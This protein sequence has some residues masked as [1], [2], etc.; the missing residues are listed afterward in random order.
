MNTF[1]KKKNEILLFEYIHQ[2]YQMQNLLKPLP[3]Y[4]VKYT[5]NCNPPCIKNDNKQTI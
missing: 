5:E 3:S 2:I 4:P 1:Q